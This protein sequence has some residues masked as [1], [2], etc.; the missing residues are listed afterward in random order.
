MFSIFFWE[1]VVTTI[2]KTNQD[3]STLESNEV[4]SKEQLIRKVFGKL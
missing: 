4:P 2:K 3:K 1:I